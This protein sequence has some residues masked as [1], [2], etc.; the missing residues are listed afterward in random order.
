M[1]STNVTWSLTVFQC[2][3]SRFSQ[4][5]YYITCLYY[6][7]LSNSSISLYFHLLTLSLIGWLGRSGFLASSC[8]CCQVSLSLVCAHTNRTYVCYCSLSTCP[9]AHRVSYKYYYTTQTLTICPK[10]SNIH[11]LSTMC[12]HPLWLDINMHHKLNRI[13]RSHV[14]STHVAKPG[15]QYNADE[16]HENNSEDAE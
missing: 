6:P 14:Y 3:T 4:L 5:S 7:I 11:L 10:Y 8:P 13:T 9:P 12:I 2:V 15:L 16:A 1:I